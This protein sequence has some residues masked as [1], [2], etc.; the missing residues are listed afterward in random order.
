MNQLSL[1]L[2]TNGI[3]VDHLTTLDPHPLNKDGF[4]QPNYSVVD[5]SASN[6]W[7]NVLFA[8]NYWEDLGTPAFLLLS[9]IPM[10]NRWPGL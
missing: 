1:L 10:A 8:D 2:G 7:A 4:N 6:T 9:L 3:W 5:A